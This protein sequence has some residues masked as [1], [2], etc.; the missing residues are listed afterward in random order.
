METN[1]ALPTDV[2]S[3][4]LR[5]WLPNQAPA[6]GNE[7]YRAARKEALRGRG[8]FIRWNHPTVARAA[9]RK[10]PTEETPLDFAR[11]SLFRAS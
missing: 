7:K 1:F 10:N 6:K 8:R 2:M 9:F 11:V 3:R 5:R 4:C